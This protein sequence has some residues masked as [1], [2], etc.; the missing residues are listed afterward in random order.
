M[1]IMVSGKGG[2]GKSTV[3]A[4]LARALARQGRDVLL[5]DADESNFGLSRLAG[6]ET[7]EIL[8]ENLGGRAGVREKMNSASDANLIPIINRPF[9]M[10]EIPAACLTEAS[11]VKVL[12]MGKVKH[13][14]EG[15]AC[16]IGALTKRFLSNLEAPADA[17]VIV[18]TEAGVEHFGRGVDGATDLILAVVDPT[19]ES[20]L[21]AGKLAEMAAQAGVALRLVLNKTDL[22]IEAAL[23]AKLKPED[24][25]AVIPQDD[26]LFLDSLE[27]RALSAEPPAVT[28]LARFVSTFGEKSRAASTAAPPPFR[29]LK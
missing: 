4:L 2:S 14:G 26:S 6:A 27:G 8:L 23:R 5:V 13:F 7:P 18:D 29:T 1:K 10:A 11:G 12:V 19:F 28:E 22:R 24:I 25:A 15:C 17:F 3:A 16:M 20:I 9:T 21:M